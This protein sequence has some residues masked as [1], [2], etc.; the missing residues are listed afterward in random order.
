MPGM[1]PKLAEPHNRARRQPDTVMLRRSGPR[2]V[3]ASDTAHRR[4]H[5]ASRVARSPLY[6]PTRLRELLTV[7]HFA[8]YTAEGLRAL[9]PECSF[10]R[11]EGV[12]TDRM[13][14]IRREMELLAHVGSR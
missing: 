13:N 6:Q 10:A 1:S 4:L 8:M 2:D 12:A 14:G 5:V 7:D 9:L 11:V 3:D